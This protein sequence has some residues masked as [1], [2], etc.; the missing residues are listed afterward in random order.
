[1]S[2]PKP[3]IMDGCGVSFWL[4]VSLFL[5]LLV[6]VGIRTCSSSEEEMPVDALTEQRRSQRIEQAKDENEETREQLTISLEEA[7]GEVLSEIQSSDRNASV[8]ASNE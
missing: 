7:E 8:E 1:M 6:P 2:D 5:L 3:D 4:I